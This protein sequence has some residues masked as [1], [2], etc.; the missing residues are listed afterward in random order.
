MRPLTLTLSAFG[1]FAGRTE[2][3][4]APLGDRGLYLIT[5]VTGAGKTT[6]FDAIAYALY[7][8]PSGADR[9][10]GMLASKYAAPDAVS[11][12]E[13]TFIHRGRTYTVQRTL[14]RDREKKRG[15]GTTTD[16][17]S[18]ALF[19][20]DGR[21][22]VVKPTE[23]TRAV[24]ELLG[25]DR[26]QFRQIAMIAQGA[27]QQLLLADTETR[28]K[29]F[30]DIFG[31]GPYLAFQNQVKNDAL[32]LDRECELLEHDMAAQMAAVR[33][34]AEDPLAMELAAYR[35]AVPSVADA[36]ALIDKLIAQDNLLLDTLRAEAAGDDSQIGALDAALG[37]AEQQAKL[38]TEA[39]QAEEWLAQNQPL[40]AGLKTA[41][42]A[43]T[44]RAEERKALEEQA[45][46]CRAELEKLTALTALQTRLDQ[47]RTQ[48]ADAETT[49]E[50]TR[51]AC[52]DLLAR[53]E[54]AKAELAA[55]G[56]AGAE[57]ER[58]AA[59]HQRLTERV[60]ALENLSAVHRDLQMLQTGLLTAQADYRRAADEAGKAQQTYE[61]EH[62]RFLD[63]QAGVLAQTL[64][65]GEPCPVCGSREHPAPAAFSG[66]ALT[67]EAL[68]L[69]R[70]H[71]DA[72][73]QTAGDHSAQAAAKRGA[74]EKAASDWAA[75]A[76]DLL[77]DLAA[78]EL[79]AALTAALAEAQD[80]KETQTAITAAAQAKALRADALRESLPRAESLLTAQ[81]T[82]R[83]N[84]EQQA[85]EKRA[86]AAELNKRLSEERQT[87]VYPDQATAE[88]ALQ[89]LQTALTV[90]ENA[91][92]AAQK[93]YN[94]ARDGIRDAQARR[95]AL[96]KQLEG[97]VP[98]DSAALCAERE[99]CAAA[100]AARLTKQQTLLERRNANAAAADALQKLSGRADTL[101]SKRTW[102]TALSQTVNGGLTGKEK[103]PLETYVQTTYLDRILTRANT[104][105]MRMSGGQYELVRRSSP[106]DLRQK[107]GLELNVTDHYNGTERDVRSLSGGEQFK[108]S[109]ALAL[110]M[111][112]EVQSQAG[113]VRLDTLFIDEGFG[114]LDE[115]SLSSAIDV[116]AS[117]SEGN[118][119]VGVISHV[120]QL[121][122][123]IDRQIVVTKAR[124]GGSRAEI[125]A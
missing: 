39:T 43:E 5:G 44:G 33:A 112:D 23:V 92:S 79:P 67:R 50:K 60:K 2:L 71:A 84:A 48:A 89:T 93:A 73:A 10:P 16:T 98:V 21:A 9:K 113:G 35:R 97:V 77:G 83:R 76:G 4:F 19:Y 26:D 115:E 85:A 8:E 31:T 17:A 61:A 68:A 47:A 120:Q 11:S 103:I 49:A 104:R 7:G 51:A 107:S 63:E 57:A 75:R 66:Q 25:V 24:T 102:L 114:T 105:L 38:F 86:E 100:R 80:Q 88:I 40:L 20:P 15:A 95:E 13:L 52:A 108:A 74:L 56:D 82:A 45:R 101:Q 81:E 27:F 87:L 118:R 18:A 28:G 90:R 30:R 62:R 3:D 78:D 70:K 53:T 65:P 119:L 34:D 123:R 58:Q 32:A 110:G 122:D 124:A 111:S 72:L 29:I 106:E 117:L 99:A 36:R 55:L 37:R 121:K 12:V 125:R 42:D 64:A 1:P 41:L 46:V 96:Q 69:L 109:L 91:L 54:K 6:L 116:L 59:E 14:P 94:D 22:P